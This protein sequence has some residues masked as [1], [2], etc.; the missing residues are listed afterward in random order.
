MGLS[1]QQGC[2]LPTLQTWGTCGHTSSQAAA[3]LHGTIP[4]SASLGPSWSLSCLS[5]GVGPV[6][7][8]T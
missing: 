1:Q 5:L 8:F 6:S 4:L 7:R 3:L 2:P